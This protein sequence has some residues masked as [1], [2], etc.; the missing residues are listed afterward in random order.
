MVAAA[1]VEKPLLDFGRAE[2]AA[3]IIA[4]GKGG[5]E[6][7]IMEQLARFGPF[8]YNSAAHWD[9]YQKDHK[10]LGTEHI[11]GMPDK[12]GF[13]TSGLLWEPG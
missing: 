6:I 2:V 11:Y 4:N 13:I 5:M 9:G 12:D 1:A 7:D 8:R 10:S 3:Q